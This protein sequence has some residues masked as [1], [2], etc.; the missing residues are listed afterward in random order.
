MP[1]STALA[2]WI[3]AY[4]RCLRDERRLSEHTLK[5]YR[6][7][8]DRFA[9]MLADAGIER[10][11]QVRATQVRAHLAGRH[12]QGAGGRSLQREL[13]AIR[14]LFRFLNDEQVAGGNPA[15]GIR[16][17][18]APRKLPKTIDA[19]TLGALMEAVSGDPL[20]IRDTAVLELLYSSGLRLAELVGLDLHRIDLSDG[21]VE[22]TGKGRKTRRLP[23]GRKACA[24]LGA[25]LQVRTQLAVRGETAVFVSRRGTRLSPRSVQA[26]VARRARHKGLGSH[27]HPHMLRHSFAS[28]LLESSSDLRAVQELLGHA[29]ISTT[30]IY[31]HL[32]FQHL[33][34][35]YDK[36][37]PRARR[38][39]QGS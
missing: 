13:S 22:V 35:V 23:V 26:R 37:H 8:L 17:P 5:G 19:D 36:T 38:S 28:H 32:D 10:W 18:R 25:W 3:D 16:A 20:E 2:P 39:R 12:R 31:T 6:R 27:L 29:D 15:L 21:M 11:D 1:D 30:Q 34:R 14:G 24:A 33:A 4:S 9:S 7:D